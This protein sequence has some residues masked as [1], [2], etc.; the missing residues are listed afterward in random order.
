MPKVLVVDDHP[1]IINAV[2]A[3]VHEI[4]PSVAVLHSRTLVQTVGF[5]RDNKDI[6][7][8]LLDL[9]LP[10]C[11][12][13]EGLTLLHREFPSLPIAIF[14]GQEHES[15]RSACLRAGLRPMS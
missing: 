1:M 7:L 14:T 8:V 6:C 10:D 3:L 5:C 13:T 2:E 12:H 11:R 4:A 9:N 15:V